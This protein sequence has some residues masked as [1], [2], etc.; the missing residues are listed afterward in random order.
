MDISVVVVLYIAGF[1]QFMGLL[2]GHKLRNLNSPDLLTYCIRGH[3]AIKTYCKF[4][5][6]RPW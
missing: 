5:N 6:S 2:K 1:T 4:Q 3:C